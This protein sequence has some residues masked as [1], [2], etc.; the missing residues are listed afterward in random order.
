[1]FSS[2]LVC[3]GL[4]PQS[5]ID[6]ATTLLHK[7]MD[8]QTVRDWQAD[9]LPLF[10]PFRLSLFG[11]RYLTFPQSSAGPWHMVQRPAPTSITK[12]IK[13]TDTS[14]R[15]WALRLPDQGRSSHR[16]HTSARHCAARGCAGPS[17]GWTTRM[18]H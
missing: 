11:P 14:C 12:S 2:S 4:F 16:T 6:E 18:Y 17:S 1:M 15:G 7:A 9:H 3:P 10:G 5:V 13:G 8:T